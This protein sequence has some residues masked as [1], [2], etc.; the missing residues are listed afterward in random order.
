MH[1]KIF[2]YKKFRLI[3]GPFKTGFAVYVFIFTA[4]WALATVNKSY[5]ET[6]NTYCIVSAPALVLWVYRNTEHVLHRQCTCVSVVSLQII[7]QRT[8]N[9]HSC[10]CI[11]TWQLVQDA[12]WRVYG[13]HKCEYLFAVV[14]SVM[15]GFRS[16]SNSLFD[17]CHSSLVSVLIYPWCILLRYSV[18]CEVKK[19]SMIGACVCL[20]V[21]LW[22]RV[23]AWRSLVRG[24]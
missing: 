16:F 4:Y 24:Y 21:C 9:S 12:W 11:C 13:I 10:Y 20:S 19:K 6:L 5:E 8:E 18:H 14:G 2:P 23:G 15:I 22:S 7:S 1:L 17:I 3:K